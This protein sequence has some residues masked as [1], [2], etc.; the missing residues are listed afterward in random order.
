M[1]ANITVLDKVIWKNISYTFILLRTGE[2]R[3]SINF[4]S[5]QS[6]LERVY[7]ILLW[8]SFFQLHSEK[9]ISTFQSY[10]ENKGA[11]VPR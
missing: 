7:F 4:K 11:G 10:Y 5:S 3:E 8:L 1:E 2:E 9:S 6:F